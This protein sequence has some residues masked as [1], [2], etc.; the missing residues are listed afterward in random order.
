MILLKVRPRDM[1][2]CENN[3]NNFIIIYLLDDK[4]CKNIVIVYRWGLNFKLYYNQFQ[5]LTIKMPI[6]SNDM[7]PIRNDIHVMSM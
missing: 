7:Y 5:I 1:N 4:I 6:I 2:S 3:V